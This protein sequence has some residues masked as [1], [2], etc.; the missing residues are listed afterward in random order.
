MKINASPVESNFTATIGGCSNILLE[1]I[2]SCRKMCMALS[3]IMP[4][5]HRGTY[6]VQ[7][8]LD[9]AIFVQV[10]MDLI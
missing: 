10:Q 9:G 1:Y 2:L 3:P 7:N 8:G 6:V 4:V 5:L